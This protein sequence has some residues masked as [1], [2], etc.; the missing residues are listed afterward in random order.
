[1]LKTVKK[2]LEK[3][4]D[5]GFIGKPIKIAH[6]WGNG[7][8]SIAW[9]LRGLFFG[10]LSATFYSEQLSVSRGI[11]RFNSQA[12]SSP[13][14]RRNIHRIE[15]GLTSRAMRPRFGESY[16]GETVLE[17]KTKATKLDDLERNWALA[18]LQE[19]FN[20]VSESPRISA[21]RKAFLEESF[22]DSELEDLS[23][24]APFLRSNE[25]KVSFEDFAALAAQRRSV[26]WFLEK[27]VDRGL[28]ESAISVAL[29]SPSSCNRLPFRVIAAFGRDE[30]SRL[31]GL[32]FGSA[33]FSDQVP[34]GIA[35]VGDFSNYF[36]ARDRHGPYI[37]SSLFAM[38]L[39][40]ALET[41]GLGSVILNW[42]E[43]AAQDFVAR[44]KLGL[45]AHE[46]VMFMM[47]IGY[48]DRARPVPR[49]AKKTAQ[50]VISELI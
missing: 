2:W 1:M 20:N 36:S 6:R 9:P 37:D 11:A 21:A 22:S 24:Y 27:P 33:G 46:R 3:L 26:R 40:Y 41:M 38:S 17:F 32:P 18:V 45:K 48:P 31:V 39:T 12:G 47:A 50:L 34:L 25:G 35:I 5:V 19:Y 8:I 30:S 28:F 13:L 42:P 14:L 23:D 43:V 4:M 7:V 10:F 44:K 16:I 29:N 15:K 49:S